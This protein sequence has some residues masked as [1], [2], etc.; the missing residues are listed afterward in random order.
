MTIKTCVYCGKE[1]KARISGQLY[2]SKRCQTRQGIIN[3][4]LRSGKILPPVADDGDLERKANKVREGWINPS[5]FRADA[6][7]GDTVYGNMVYL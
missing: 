3:R 7:D 6:P 2:C 5:P 1:Y 4:M